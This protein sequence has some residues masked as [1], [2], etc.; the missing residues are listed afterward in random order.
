MLLM[1]LLLAVFL[2][3]FLGGN[4]PLH[5][6]SWLNQYFTLLHKWPTKVL[7][8]PAVLFALAAGLCAVAL[9]ALTS[10]LNTHSSLFLGLFAATVL[11]Y[12]FGRGE[13]NAHITQFIVAEA[14]NDWHDALDAA[15]K[16]GITHLTE[17]DSNQKNWLK[18]NENVLS[19]VSYLGF[20]RLFA[21]IFWFVILGPVGAFI[22]RF[23]QLWLARWP[24]EAI[25][26]FLWVIEWPAARILG[27]SLAIT[28]NFASCFTAWKRCVLCMRRSSEQ[29]LMEN[30]MASLAVD[31][32][33]LPTQ[34]VTRR[35][36]NAI[37]Q[38]LSRTLW[39]WLGAIALFYII[40]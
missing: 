22:Y 21:V 27:L 23:T 9:T 16:L 4:N 20:E 18:L 35:E 1:S 24:S 29:L 12:S 38:L 6:D 31:E 10:F 36:L 30:V 34:E 32:Q 5:Q 14:K 40:A 2:K 26:R 7:V 19:K 33:L 37:Q 15:K 11:L 13:L 3:Q 25:A 39:L 28:G 17:A 8:D